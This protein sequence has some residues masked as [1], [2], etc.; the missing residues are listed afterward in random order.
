[1]RARD[2]HFVVIDTEHRRETAWMQSKLA[3]Q[4]TVVRMLQGAIEGNKRRQVR[5]IV[6]SAVCLGVGL[7]TRANVF[8]L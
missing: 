8:L 6:C 1:M 5:N 4:T 3:E 2:W 7:I